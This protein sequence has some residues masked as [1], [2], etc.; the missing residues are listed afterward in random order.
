[1]IDTQRSKFEFDFLGN[2]LFH[3]FFKQ[4]FLRGLHE[5]ISSNTFQLG[6]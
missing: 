6:L 1:M 2:E 5:R 3:R 4:V